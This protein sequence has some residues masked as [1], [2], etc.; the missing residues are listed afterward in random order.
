MGDPLLAEP[1]LGCALNISSGAYG[2]M[3]LPRRV[4]IVSNEMNRESREGEAM[5]RLRV[6]A[7]DFAQMRFAFSPITEL[8][9]S[10]YMLHSGYAHPPYRRWAERARKRM[11]GLDNELLQAVVPH[12]GAIPCF[13]LGDTGTALTIGQQL[14]LLAD[15]PL[16]LLRAELEDVWR[17]NG[18]PPAA[19]QVIAAG[20]AGT[21]RLADVLWSYWESVLEPHWHRMQ[22]VLEAD[23]TYRAR[24][25]TRGGL[26]ALLADLH[27]QLQLDQDCIH[28]DK[29]FHCEYNLAG[30]GL[31]LMPSIFAPDVLFCPADSGPPS[32]VYRTRGVAV[33][34]EA[35][36]A[37]Q[38]AED[39][40]C[41]LIG[42]SRTAI[43]RSAAAPKSTTELA[44]DLGQACATVSVHL[45]ILRR[46]DMITSWRSG[47][48]ILHQ[49]TPLAASLLTNADKQRAA[50]PRDVWQPARLGSG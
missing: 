35:A 48:R 25:L 49:R 50:E 8:V 34:W 16:D 36:S 3:A 9:D 43:L 18:L 41:A 42:H 5:I 30:D 11:R 38:A 33:V 14:Q 24:Q 39:P 15:W 32:L 46:C 45:T 13:P 44:R 22:A 40:L 23:V 21:R 29:P 19:E 26:A 20:P 28:I 10:L 2:I 37:S 27:P 7:G 6:A 12:L 4:I 1:R 31:L 17:G 47:R